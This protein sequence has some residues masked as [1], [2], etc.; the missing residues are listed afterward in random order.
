MDDGKTDSCRQW[1]NQEGQQIISVIMQ[2]HDGKAF[3]P[4][5]IFTPRGEGQE[6]NTDFRWG[7][8]RREGVV[9]SNSEN[10]LMPDRRRSRPSLRGR[11]K[12]IASG[13]PRQDPGRD[14]LKSAAGR[15]SI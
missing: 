13:S 5:N 11:K 9:G 14:G 6:F 8:G 12:K 2:I 4:G 3:L 10:T 1:D 15:P 7:E